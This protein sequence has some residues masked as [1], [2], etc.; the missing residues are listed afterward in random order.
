MSNNRV[1]VYL[2]SKEV[3]QSFM[4][5][6]GA[7]INIADSFIPARRLI[8]PA[9]RIVLSNVSPCIPH[10]IIEEALRSVKLKPV[11][12]ISFIGAGMGLEEYKH[13]MSFRR[14]VFIAATEN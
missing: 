6:H 14:Q 4:V 8:T 7:G 3:V 2:S 12:P 9:K 1:C 13:V 5:T 10:A 11:S